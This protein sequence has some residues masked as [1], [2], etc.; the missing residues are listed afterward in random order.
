MVDFKKTMKILD[1]TFNGI[2][3]VELVIKTIS[4]GF[5]LDY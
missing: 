1:Y 5:I 4:K 3:A 2:F